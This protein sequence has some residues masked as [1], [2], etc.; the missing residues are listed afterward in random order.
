MKAI[1]IDGNSLIYRVY[2]ATFKMLPFY[3]KNNLTPT[4]AVNLF[5]KCLFKL[6][7]N[8]K[9]SYFFVAFDH[10]K[11]TFRTKMLNQ[12]KANRKSMPNELAVQLPIVKQLL[13]LMGIKYLSL[14]NFE[15]DDLIGSYCKLMN[16]NQIEVDIF[17]SDKDML[18]LVNNLTN[19]NLF[20]VG[21]SQIT[22]YTFDNFSSLF[23]GLTPNQIVDYKSITGDGSDNF[24]GIKG[25]GPKTAI[26][27][28]KK[29]T[30]LENIYKNLANLNLTQQQKFIQYQ[31]Q[32]E[33]CYQLAKI[34]KDI[35]LDKNI[36][37]FLRKDFNVKEFINYAKK[38]NLNFEKLIK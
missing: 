1:V 3:Q 9:Y 28:L 36:N 13:N 14:E 32:G 23:Y 7:E 17:T 12:Y 31:K 5:I 33:L 27:L 10:S 20:K 37:E 8:N 22:K 18:Q 11:Y 15:A 30:Y 16:D 21:I 34:K 6:I 4:N 24:S 2:W 19:V 35:F 38:F 29:Y 25:I 26:T